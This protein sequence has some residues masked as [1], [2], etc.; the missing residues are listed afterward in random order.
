MAKQLTDD[1]IATAENIFQEYLRERG[2]KYTRE[3]QTLLREVLENPDHFEAE[4]LLI[5]MR[6]AGRRVA[7]ATI[8]RTLPLLVSC[9]IIR[10]VQFGDKLTRYE[11]AFGQSPHDHM[12]CR[13]CH[14]I[15]EFSSSDVVKLRTVLA[16]RYKFH[17]QSH[18]FQ[19]SGLC[20]AC[21]EATPPEE[22]PFI[23]SSDSETDMLA[24]GD[25]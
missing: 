23:P 3:R 16:A 9:G 10:Q 8:Y 17:A 5:N 12:V 1:E 22:R 11:H 2:L 15:I 21:I 20:S 19:I 13:R 24:D 25:V 4:Q 14:R 18:R 7:K 6:Q